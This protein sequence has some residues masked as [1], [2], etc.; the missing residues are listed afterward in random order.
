MIGES[1]GSQR[2]VSSA[3]RVEETAAFVIFWFQAM[4]KREKG[5]GKKKENEND[6]KNESRNR[7]IVVQ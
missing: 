4:S 7:E 3:W 6:Q 1:E 2:V 5:G